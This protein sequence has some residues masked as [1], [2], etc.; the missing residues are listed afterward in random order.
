[1][2]KV[3]LLL[4]TSWWPS[5]VKLKTGGGYDLEMLWNTN[6][7]FHFIWTTWENQ[8]C[9]HTYMAEQTKWMNAWLSYI[10]NS[11]WNH[12]GKKKTV[13]SVFCWRHFNVPSVVCCS[14][15]KKKEKSPEETQHL[16]TFTLTFATVQFLKA[17]WSLLH[18]HSSATECSL[19]ALESQNNI[20]PRHA[21]GRSKVDKSLRFF[22]FPSL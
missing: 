18:R 15:K 7:S 6:S 21:K 13:Q 17:N 22:G 4:T 3:H 8:W 5:A 9:P 10:S 20:S 11:R 16:G 1:M 14:V 19:I 2:I 12:Y